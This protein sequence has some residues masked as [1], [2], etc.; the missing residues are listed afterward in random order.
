LASGSDLEGVVFGAVAT[1]EGGRAERDY[2]IDG[3]TF[4]D[5]STRRRERIGEAV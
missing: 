5:N 2:Y 4:N 1:G 3:G